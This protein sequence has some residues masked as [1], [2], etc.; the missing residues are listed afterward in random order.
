M[1]QSHV[2]HSICISW[3]GIDRGCACKKMPHLSQNGVACIVIFQVAPCTPHTSYTSTSKLHAPRTTGV[4]YKLLHLPGETNATVSME[5]NHIHCMPQPKSQPNSSILSPTKMQHGTNEIESCQLSSNFSHTL[6][7]VLTCARCPPS[8]VAFT[9]VCASF[10]LPLIVSHWFFYSPLCFRTCRFCH[11]SWLQHSNSSHCDAIARTVLSR[12]NLPSLLGLTASSP[13]CIQHLLL[14]QA[15]DRVLVRLHESYHKK[16]LQSPGSRP[17]ISVPRCLL[18]SLLS[19]HVFF[20][21]LIS[22]LNVGL[23][24]FLWREHSFS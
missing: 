1:W 6:L 7:L 19:I 10:L 22:I 16:Q 24:F 2:Y 8:Q 18:L 4:K 12:Y 15:V 9:C 11:A 13:S 17:L 21:L 14:W 20:C 3:C 23:F 5:S